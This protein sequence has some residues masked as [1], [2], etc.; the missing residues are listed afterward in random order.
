MSE[1]GGWYTQSDLAQFQ[2]IIPSDCRLRVLHYL[3]QNDLYIN[4]ASVSKNCYEDTNDESLPQSRMGVIHCGN[5]TMQFLKNMSQP[6]IQ[7]AFEPPRTHLKLIGHQNIRSIELNLLSKSGAEI[8][9][10]MSGAKLHKVSSLDL[11]FCENTRK[12][13]RRIPRCAIKILS[14]LL[15]NVQKLEIS[16]VEGELEFPFNFQFDFTQLIHIKWCNVSAGTFSIYGDQFQPLAHL[17]KLDLDN[18][19]LHVPRESAGDR[20]P[21][22]QLLFE[23]GHEP[24]RCILHDCRQLEEVS[25]KSATYTYWKLREV[26]PLPQSGLAKFVRMM[27]NL[28]WFRSDLKPENVEKLR[29]DQLDVVFT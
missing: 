26:C 20:I 15:P 22:D 3:N 10:L 11:S 1:S 21:N 17:I 29:Q 12:G 23:E 18:V 4:Y 13:D 19:C 2:S 14:D 24:P 7:K 8:D 5:D 27:P 6:W 28:R 25:L 9:D 16:N